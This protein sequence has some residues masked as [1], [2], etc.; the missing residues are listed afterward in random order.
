MGRFFTQNSA[1]AGN[2]VAAIDDGNTD[3][4]RASITPSRADLH[5]RQNNNIIPTST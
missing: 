1:T 3:A 4:S 5:L 2:Q